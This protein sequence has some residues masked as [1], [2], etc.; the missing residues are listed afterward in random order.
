MLKIRADGIDWVNKIESPVRLSSIYT[1]RIFDLTDIRS[2]GR[3]RMRP[4]HS[5]REVD[6][7]I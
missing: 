3:P 4:V 7:S 1:M 5:T 2:A 6:T